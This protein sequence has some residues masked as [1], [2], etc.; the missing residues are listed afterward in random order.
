L[1]RG[2]PSGARYE[3][4]QDD[5]EEDALLGRNHEAST[6]DTRLEE[7]ADLEQGLPAVPHV[8]SQS[9]WLSTLSSNIRDRLFIRPGRVAT[10]V[11]NRD[12]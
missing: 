2:S 7:N 1:A 9:G 6:S 4:Y 10:D 11:E 5:S 8:S 12:R 3:P